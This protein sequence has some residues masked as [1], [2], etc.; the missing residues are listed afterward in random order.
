MEEVVN[1]FLAKTSP[2][3]NISESVLDHDYTLLAIKRYGEGAREFWSYAINGTRKMESIVAEPIRAFLHGELRN[4]KVCNHSYI[5]P[6]R[7]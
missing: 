5:L 4:F 3:P 6:F 1:G 2:P 7:E